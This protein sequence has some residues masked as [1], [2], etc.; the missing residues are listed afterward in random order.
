MFT[1]A[2]FPLVDTSSRAVIK[3][4][5][6]PVGYCETQADKRSISSRRAKKFLISL[7]TSI[8]HLIISD[9]RNSEYRG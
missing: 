3:L 6:H 7:V 2:L 9:C 8:S 1:R 5:V 4:D